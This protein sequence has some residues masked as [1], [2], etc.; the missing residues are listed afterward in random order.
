VLRSVNVPQPEATALQSLQASV[1][2]LVAAD[3]SPARCAGSS[4]TCAERFAAQTPS[5][6][7]W[8]HTMSGTL[9]KPASAMASSSSE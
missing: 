8:I 6:S 4:F 2:R 9:G 7:R 1:G 5:Q 3:F